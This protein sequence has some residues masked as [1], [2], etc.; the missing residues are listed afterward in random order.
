MFP[1]LSGLITGGASLLGNI[2]SSNTSAQNTQANIAQQQYA[3]AES[4]QF[5]A[6]QAQQNRD[7]QAS[8]VTQQEAFQEQMSNTAFQRARADMVK[9]GINP[10]LAAG[11][12][13]ASTPSGSAAS[14]SSASVGVPSM[15]FANKRSPLGDLGA[16][17]SQAVSSAISAK[18][19][20][21]M[22]EEIAN[23]DATRK[24]IIADTA[25]S[26]QKERLVGSEA[27]QAGYGVTSAQA[28]AER[29]KRYID[30]P[31]WLKNAV[32]YARYGAGGVESVGDAIGSFAP[33]ARAAREFMP[34]RSTTQRSSVDQYGVKSEMFEDRWDNLMGAYQRP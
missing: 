3:Q 1:L 2:F 33:T 28:A 18:T 6:A 25:V 22:T 16:V 27:D 10:I 5:N 20:D 4:E 9:A 31:D 30:M 8:Q 23:L 19:F 17:A 34:R 13:G 11:G 7:F 21:K 24:A 29:A 14:G 15:G 32:E 12:S 26:R